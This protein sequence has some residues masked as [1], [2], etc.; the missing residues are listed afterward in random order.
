MGVM[1]PRG[2]LRGGATRALRALAE[3]ASE[4]RHHAPLRLGAVA[5]IALDGVGDDAPLRARA[6]QAELWG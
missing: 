6:E 1:E 3:T 4:F 5:Q 2:R